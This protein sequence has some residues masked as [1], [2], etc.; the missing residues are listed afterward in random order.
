MSCKAV[1]VGVVLA[2]RQAQWHASSNRRSGPR[3]KTDGMAKSVALAETDTRFLFQDGA[4]A[5]YTLP[6]GFLLRDFEMA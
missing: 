4:H 3:N 2:A 6:D 1:H 5:P